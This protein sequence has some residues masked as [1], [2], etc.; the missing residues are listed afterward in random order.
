MFG[1]RS[2]GLKVFD[3]NGKIVFPV[4][5]TID[6][7]AREVIRG[8]WGNGEERKKRPTNAGY[9]YHAVQRRLNQLL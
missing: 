7:L 5:K 1:F 3:E 6:E 2:F 4:G 9:D 8:D